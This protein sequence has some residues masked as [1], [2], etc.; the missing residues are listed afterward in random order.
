[1]NIVC[2]TFQCLLDGGEWQSEAVNW[3][4][5]YGYNWNKS[6]AVS[7]PGANRIRLHFSAINVEAGYDHLRTDVG[8][9]WS[10]NYTNVTSREKSGNSIGLTLASDGSVTGYFVIDR[11]EYQGTSAGPATRSG[12]LF[13]Q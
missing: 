7:K 6:G 2:Q 3:R 11:V 13:A 1:M 5:N 12:S 9:H 8:D 10:G 4:A